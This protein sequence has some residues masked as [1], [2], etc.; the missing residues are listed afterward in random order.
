MKNITIAFRLDDPS[1][2]SPIKIERNLIQIFSEHNATCTFGVVPYITLGDYH[3][4]KSEGNSLLPDEKISLFKEAAKKKVI[5]IALHGYEHKT[6]NDGS[7]LHSEFCGG[8]INQQLEKIKNGKDILEKQFEAPIVS[9][10]PPWNTYDKNTLKALAQNNINCISSNRYQTVSQGEMSYLPITLELPDLEYAV[11]VARNSN[12]KSPSIIILMHPYDFKESGD[13]RAQYD[14][15]HI[16]DTLSWIASQPD[17]NIASI[18]QLSNDSNQY[19]Y[20]RYMW[21]KSSFLEN[22]FLP[23]LTKTDDIPIY[24]STSSARNKKI[25]NNSV[26]IL[27]YV[28]ILLLSAIMANQILEFLSDS[29]PF[30][31][32]VTLALSGLVLAVLSIKAFKQKAFYFRSF[33]LSNLSLGTILGLSLI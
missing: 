11:E 19:D 13:K 14:C 15:N 29:I 28:I 26:T 33:L 4:M 31:Y 10:I 17:L 23:G 5:D 18:S 2:V 32:E 27:F 21:N 22:I 25:R 24:L 1:A 3:E 9:F 8:D 30:I 20:R 7:R 12:D 16:D 6:I